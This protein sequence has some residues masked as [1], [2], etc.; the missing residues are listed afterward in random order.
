MNQISHVIFFSSTKK[1]DCRVNMEGLVE[2]TNFTNIGS[3]QRRGPVRGSAAM[4]SE[5]V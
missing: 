1:I 2:Q 4:A 5:E 3:L